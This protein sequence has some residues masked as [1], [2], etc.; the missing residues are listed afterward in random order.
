MAF[1]SDGNL[2]NMLLDNTGE[3]LLVIWR[4]IKTKQ[5]VI[6]I[7]TALPINLQPEIK[8]AKSLSIMTNIR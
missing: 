1:P 2:L 6:R 4:I 7:N 5:I 8:M 3:T